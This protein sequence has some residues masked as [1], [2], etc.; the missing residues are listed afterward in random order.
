MHGEGTIVAP[1]TPRNRNNVSGFSR[2]HN[3]AARKRERNSRNGSPAAGI[4]LH[5]RTKT[6][7]PVRES[8]A[9]LGK[10]TT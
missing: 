5:T 8:K 3:L 9:K 2:S 4:S 10:S 6:E 1:P 7:S